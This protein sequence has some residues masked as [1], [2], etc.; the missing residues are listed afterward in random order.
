MYEISIFASPKINKV[1]W[2]A[3]KIRL[4][5]HADGEIK[6]IL[7][8]T[9]VRMNHDQRNVGIVKRCPTAHVAAECHRPAVR[10]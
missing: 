5:D 1:K 8:K 4:Y 7:K 3:Q 9:D 10:L 2:E 6:I